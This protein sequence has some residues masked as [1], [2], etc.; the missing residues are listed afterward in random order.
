MAGMIEMSIPVFS[1]KTKEWMITSHL[2]RSRQV[3]DLSHPIKQPVIRSSSGSYRSSDRGQDLFNLG[4][5][6]EMTATTRTPSPTITKRLLVI[7]SLCVFFLGQETGGK[8]LSPTT[9]TVLRRHKP[10]ELIFS[11]EFF[12]F[13]TSIWYHEHYPPGHKIF[14]NFLWISSSPPPL[15]TS[16]SLFLPDSNVN[17]GRPK[18]TGVNPVQQL[19][20]ASFTLSVALALLRKEIGGSGGGDLFE[21]SKMVKFTCCVCDSKSG[22]RKSMRSANEDSLWGIL[23]GAVLDIGKIVRPDDLVCGG[24]FAFL[25]VNSKR[26]AV[27]LQLR[28]DQVAKSRPRSFSKPTPC[29]DPVASMEL[30]TDVLPLPP[31]TDQNVPTSPRIQHNIPPPHQVVPVPVGVPRIPVVDV[32]IPSV[33]STQSH[34][35]V[36]K[37]PVRTRI[38]KRAIIEVFIRRGILIPENN[39]CCREH[40][41]GEML[42]EDVLTSLV[43]A[44]DSS[45]LTGEQVSKWMVTLRGI[46]TEKKLPIDFSKDSRLTNSDYEM[47]LGV[48]ID[49]FDVLLAHCQGSVRNTA[50]RS[51]RNS[52]AIF[53]MKL[54]LNLSQ[55]VIA[56]LFGISHQSTI[57]ETISSVLKSLLASFAPLYTGYGHKTGQELFDQHMRPFFYIYPWRP[58]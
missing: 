20:L 58:S 10:K 8:D 29:E 24:C 12:D 52:L 38:K 17:S 11:D 2:V 51:V 55:R 54:R 31:N 5:L 48:S 36:C 22:V 16:A 23:R 13:D 25:H 45:S 46:I 14:V 41:H 4:I 15:D 28:L 21:V 3:D 27:N 6:G 42:K 32:P 39:R 7:S 37:S 1:W 57:S 9:T 40:L 47:L 19:K 44:R 35:F 26:G 18:L 49:N 56:F 33:I 34:C 30:D 50:N 43:S 53:L